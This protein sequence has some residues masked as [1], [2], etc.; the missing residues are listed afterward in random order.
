MINFSGNGAPDRN[1]V[2]RQSVPK[3]DIGCNPGAANG[4][5]GHLPSWRYHQVPDGLAL[6]VRCWQVIA[7]GQ[8]GVTC[9][10]RMPR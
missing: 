7:V 1:A 6:C 3:S 10:G 9:G 2:S 5:P 8:T 4:L